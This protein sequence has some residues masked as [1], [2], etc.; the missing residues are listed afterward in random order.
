MATSS[1]EDDEIRFVKGLLNINVNLD[2]TPKIVG[3]LALRG[4]Y[5]A[6]C[7]TRGRQPSHDAN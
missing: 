1:A 5:D 4:G 7:T 2:A 3:S 6:G